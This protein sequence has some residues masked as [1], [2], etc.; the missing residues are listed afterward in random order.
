MIGLDEVKCDTNLLGFDIFGY[1]LD[2]IFIGK[3]KR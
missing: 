1:M 3:G 2:S